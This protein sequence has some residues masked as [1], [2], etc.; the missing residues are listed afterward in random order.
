MFIVSITQGRTVKVVHV[1][2]IKE[3][4]QVSEDFIKGFACHA[5]GEEPSSLFG[6]SIETY[7]E[8]WVQGATVTLHTD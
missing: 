8:G 2:G 7:G 4:R 3:D 1:S 5:A 6:M